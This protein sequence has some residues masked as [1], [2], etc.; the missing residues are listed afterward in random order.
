MSKSDKLSAKEV[1]AMCNMTAKNFRKHLRENSIQAE[2]KQKQYE[3][4]SKQADKIVAQF[5]AD[6]EIEQSEDARV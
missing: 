4:T 3:F 2:R 6:E 1:A 5:A